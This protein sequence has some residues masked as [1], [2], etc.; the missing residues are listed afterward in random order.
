MPALNIAEMGIMAPYFADPE[1]LDQ[2][3][4]ELDP[5]RQLRL[6]WIHPDCNL[7]TRQN[8]PKWMLNA[9]LGYPILT[10]PMDGPHWRERPQVRAAFKDLVS[11]AVARV[12]QSGDW[13]K[14]VLTYARWRE[15]SSHVDYFTIWLRLL[16]SLTRRRMR[17]LCRINDQLLVDRVTF[18]DPCRASAD[19]CLWLAMSHSSYMRANGK[20]CPDRRPARGH[21]IGLRPNAHEIRRLRDKCGLTQAAL[22]SRLAGYD[23]RDRKKKSG[24]SYRTI[25]R[26]ESDTD[27]TMDV[28]T[29]QAIADTLDALQDERVTLQIITLK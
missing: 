25:Q 8:R 9:V 10:T 3:F 5:E 28:S 17:L 23:P 1:R 7:A 4:R 26:A 11:R 6:V 20:A 21:P 16:R 2:Q 29:L 15:D 12:R 27:V 18:Q 24:L 19:L 22:G 13:G 14:A